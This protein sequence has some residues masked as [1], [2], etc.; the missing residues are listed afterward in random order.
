MNYID[1]MMAVDENCYEVQSLIQSVQNN[2]DIE[3]IQLENKQQPF[4]LK[5]SHYKLCM[6]SSY[7][8]YVLYH[9]QLLVQSLMFYWLGFYLMF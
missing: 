4:H 1:Q 5:I 8:L 3:E 7:I 6:S 2:Q 9:L